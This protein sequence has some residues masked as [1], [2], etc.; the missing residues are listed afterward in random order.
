[1]HTLHKNNASA[2]FW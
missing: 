2:V 1:M